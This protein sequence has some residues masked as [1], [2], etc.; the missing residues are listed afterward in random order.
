MTSSVAKSYQGSAGS[1][2]V[3][4]QNLSAAI[5]ISLSESI[6]DKTGQG[7]PL[8]RLHSIWW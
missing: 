7:D 2:V 5:M 6:G 1:L 4:V 8:R 3:T